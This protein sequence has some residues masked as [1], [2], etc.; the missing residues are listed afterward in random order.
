MGADGIELDTMLSADG[1]P[2]VIHDFTLERTTDG[3]GRVDEQ[4]LDKLRELDAGGHFSAEFRGEPLPTLAE[5]LDAF[6]SA[7]RI[8]I[9]LKSHS[10]GDNGLEAR[11]VELIRQ[12]GLGPSII[13][14]SFNPLSLWRVRRLAPEIQRGLLYAPD[15]PLYLRRAWTAPFLALA[16]MHP[17]SR[18]VD[19]RYMRWA[20]GKG[21]RVNV[22][23]V[24]DPPEMLRL[25]ELGVDA[26][27]TDRPDVARKLVDA[28]RR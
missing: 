15:L 11:V 21:Y 24:N 28:G 14:S 25:I 17:Q 1:V 2:V 12:R 6:G 26:L 7:L 3:Q 8:N 23:T 19:A 20:R 10:P 16:A 13:F 4:P 18:M 22:W 5:V 27:I 9:E